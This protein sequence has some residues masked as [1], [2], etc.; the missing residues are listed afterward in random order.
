M[1]ITRRRWRSGALVALVPC[2]TVFSLAGFSSRAS[3]S[4][5]PLSAG[6]AAP[7]LGASGT[8]ADVTV[9]SCVTVRPAASV[10]VRPAVQKSCA[11]RRPAGTRSGHPSPGPGRPSGPAA[12]RSFIAPIH[13]MVTAVTGAH[14]VC[15][16]GR[17]ASPAGGANGA[18]S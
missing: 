13:G 14:V 2:C 10:A 12:A 4:G 3:G 8:R 18:G 17:G 5:A 11:G 16:T 6:S 15:S 7:P 9:G 1:I